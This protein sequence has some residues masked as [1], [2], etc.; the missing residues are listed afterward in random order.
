MA[1][2]S[3]K[4]T[5]RA[6]ARTAKR[7]TKRA[8]QAKDVPRMREKL[9]GRAVAWLR[10][11]RELID[12][13]DNDDAKKKGNSKYRHNTTE[14]LD[15]YEQN[16]Y[17][18]RVDYKLSLARERKDGRRFVGKHGLQRCMRL[19]RHMITLGLLR[20]WDIRNAYAVLLVPQC[21]GATHT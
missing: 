7:H 20:D 13:L 12:K 18:P 2:D 3:V 8:G 21:G 4:S 6:V 10:R 15:F 5:S 9:Y 1:V 17:E 19:V 11:N 16:G 14:L